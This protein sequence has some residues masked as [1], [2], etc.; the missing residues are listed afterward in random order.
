MTVA[1]GAEFRPILPPV[2]PEPDP[3]ILL[4]GR[5]LTAL[6]DLRSALGNLTLP[7]PIV[8]V[9]EPDFEGLVQAMMGT[10][11]DLLDYDRLAGIVRDA[12]DIPAPVVNVE[13]P[14]SD[15]ELKKVLEGLAFSL[16]GLGRMGSGGGSVSLQ[17]G[18]TVGVTGTPNLTG[19][20]GYA[21]STLTSGSLTGV[22]RCIGIRVVAQGADGS[23]NVN[24]GDTITARQS[25][26]VDINPGAQLTAPIV[27]WVSGTLDVVIEGLS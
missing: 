4:Y 18:Q 20:W 2:I 24:G 26:G 9:T 23:F 15:G 6:G 10:R 21:A 19:T 7:A 3:A 14:S 1:L 12:I 16:Q 13:A 27:N 5:I 25:M 8:N 11:N 22:G 17:P